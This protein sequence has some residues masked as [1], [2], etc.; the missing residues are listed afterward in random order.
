MVGQK[1][2]KGRGKNIL[3]IITIQKTLRRQ[4]CYWGRRELE[5]LLA[6]GLAI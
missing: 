6:A 2:F 5:P 1:Y 3:N 4:A